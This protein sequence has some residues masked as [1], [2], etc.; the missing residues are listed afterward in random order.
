MTILILG[1]IFNPCLLYG[2]KNST[3]VGGKINLYLPEPIGATFSEN[4]RNVPRH[5]D[6]GGGISG[7]I[8]EEYY[9]VIGCLGLRMTFLHIYKNGFVVGMGC[10]IDY[11]ITNMHERNY[12]NAVGTSQR[13]YGAALTYCKSGIY[14][15][16]ASLAGVKPLYMLSLTPEF[17][18]QIPLSKKK[19]AKLSITVNYEALMA[20]NGW[21]R[22]DNYVVN[23]RL[24]LAHM[25]PIDCGIVWGKNTINYELGARTILVSKTNVGKEFNVKIPPVS[26]YFSIINNIN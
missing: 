22:Y 18:T 15:P 4:F 26:L 1:V 10:N 3:F 7:P 12:T 23:D 19:S 9:K 16:L 21:D 20:I 25:F 24:V 14:G 8:P 2:Q 17:V 5:D 11:D 6:D 13:G